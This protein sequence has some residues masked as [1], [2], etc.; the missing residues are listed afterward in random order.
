[1]L[2]QRVSEIPDHQSKAAVDISHKPSPHPLRNRLLR[3]VWNCTYLVLFR[4]SPRPFHGWRRFLLRCFGAKLGTRAKVFSTARVWAPW[5]LA[6]GDYSTIAPDVDCY[7]VS[8]ITIGSHTTVSQYCF[9]CTASHDYQHRNFLLFSKPIAIGA[10]C[11]LAADVF[12]GPGVR[13]GDGTVV[14][15]RSTVLS[16]LPPWHVCFGTP[17]KAVRTREIEGG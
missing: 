11:W 3:V 4:P 12:V 16:D 9:L 14:G 7:C 13:I 10:G 2:P 15:V 6:L 17:A 8:P 1:M 5:N